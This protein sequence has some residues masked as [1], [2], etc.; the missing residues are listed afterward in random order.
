[1]LNLWLRVNW[2]RTQFAS[3]PIAL[4]SSNTQAWVRSFAHHWPGRAY[5][6]RVS[7]FLQDVRYGG[8]Q[9]RHRKG[10]SLLAIL[11]LALGV[12]ASTAIFSVV[13]STMLRPLPY[14]APEQL[15]SLGITE[16]RP[17]GKT[18]NTG[19]SM[20]DLLFLRQASDLFSFVEGFG[21]TINGHIA[22]GAEPERLQ[23]VQFTEGYLAMHGVRP[24]TGRDFS[25]ADTTPGA[26]LVAMLGYGYWQSRFGGRDV[27]GDTIRL[28]DQV[29]TIIGVLPRTFNPNTPI[30]LPLVMPINERGRRGSGS[31]LSVVARLQPGVSIETAVE[32]GSARLA[33]LSPPG[34][35]TASS[36]PVKLR[37]T[38]RLA[39]VTTPQRSTVNVLMGAVALV[40]L[41]A[42]V[43]VAGLL[44]ARGATRRAE[45]AVRASL[46]ATRLRLVRQLVSESLAIAVPGAALGVMLA[47][48][49]LDVLVANVPVVIPSNSPAAINLT[50]LGATLALLVPTVLIVGLLPAI[51]LS[52]VRLNDALAAGGRS[53][54]APLSRRG[55]QVFIAIEVA[56][57]VLLVAGAGLMIRS[58]S[59][60]AAV[61]L[62]YVPNGLLAMNVL[63]LD[64]TPGVHTQFYSALVNRI[65]TLPG[66]TNA[67]VTDYFHLA[68]GLRTTTVKGTG[69]LE[70]VTA[71]RVSPGYFDTIA[72][73]LVAGRWP[74]TADAQSGAGP[75]VINQTA[76]RLLFPDGAAIGREITRGGADQVHTVVGVMADL[77]NGGPT[78][79]RS[80]YQA[81]VF[82]PFTVAERDVTSAMT[83]VTRTSGDPADLAGSFRHIAQSLGPR[84]LVENIR[85]GEELLSQSVLT[86]KKR[87]VMLGLLGGLGLLLALVG[88]VGVTAYA[89]TRRTREIGVRLAFGARPSQVVLAV[90]RDA[91]VP[92]GAGAILGVTAA[93]FATQL[94]KGFLFETSPT[95]PVTL[96]SVTLLLV[97]AGLFAALWPSLRAARIDPVLSLRQD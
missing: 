69:G 12:G 31:R 79:G 30:S 27:I 37:V 9:L 77:Q 32:R 13:D 34:S 25:G 35:P 20:D 43:N 23:T 45:V 17:D 86:P 49:S 4:P 42:C 94:I 61:D 71:Y 8:R 40:L 57:A 21:S 67:A 90:L 63:P 48:V 60:L 78:G 19:P 10:S 55:G 47:W 74:V 36:Q 82:F 26:P 51:R 14:P 3:G 38:S 62:G 44:M 1:M 56:V 46:G 33:G 89:V 72:A 18:S 70:M 59:K 96:A 83:I 29:A 6:A 68:S 58:F 91:A 28:D 95:D 15:V 39:T 80:F 76:A 66:V 7:T 53:G 11:T 93:A 81:H 50:V 92:I 16:P 24:L 65:S 97:V 88:I 64:R 54:S 41:L 87:T 2:V 85:T 52:G 84:A 75:A 73:T 22:G 5:N